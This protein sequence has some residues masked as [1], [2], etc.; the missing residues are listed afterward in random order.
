MKKILYIDEVSQW[1]YD[2]RTRFTKP[3]GGTENAITDHAEAFVKL[4]YDVTI[5]CGSRA[6]YY[7]SPTGVRYVPLNMLV[8]VLARTGYKPDVIIAMRVPQTFRF[9]AL[10]PEAKRIC[11]IHDLT[12]QHHTNAQAYNQFVHNCNVLYVGVS[13]WHKNYFMQGM[14]SNIP[15]LAGVAF[16]YV[17]ANLPDDF[18]GNKLATVDPFKLVHMAAPWKGLRRTVEVFKEIHKHDPRFKLFIT[19]PGYASEQVELSE[20]CVKIGAV[21]H[22]EALQHLNESFCMFHMNKVP[23][24]FGMVYAEAIA[25]GVPILTHKGAGAVDEVIADNRFLINTDDTNA[26]INRLFEWLDKGRPIPSV[27]NSKFR[28]SNAMKKWVKIIEDGYR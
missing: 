2:D 4:G 25:S 28:R 14:A 15:E 1:E 22:K 13:Q 12:F 11:W 9:F 18:K 16:D 5:A 7:D 19:D 24:T 23:E 27:L 21:S 17:Y 20:G 6:T 3:Q 8:S 10:W 26:V